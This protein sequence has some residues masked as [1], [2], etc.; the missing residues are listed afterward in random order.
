LLLIVKLQVLEVPLQAPLHP[1]MYD[2]LA[3]VAVSFTA[4]P[5]ANDLEHVGLQLIPTGLLVIV[6]LPVPFTVTVNV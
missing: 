5:A 6:P 4:V 1:A 2:P 3:A